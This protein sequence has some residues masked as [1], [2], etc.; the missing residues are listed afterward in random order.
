MSL[1]RPA[2]SLWHTGARLLGGA[3]P[4]P[5]LS[6]GGKPSGTRVHGVEWIRAA[7]PM[8]GLRIEHVEA[9]PGGSGPNR[10]FGAG[11]LTATGAN[12]L[13]WQAPYESVAGPETTVLPEQTVWVPGV[14]PTGAVL[15]TRVLDDALSGAET[16]VLRP[17]YHNVIGGDD[18][19][20]AGPIKPGDDVIRYAGL[21]VRNEHTSETVTVK[22]YRIHY[23][24]LSYVM[25]GFEALDAAGAMQTI[26]DGATAPVGVT[27]VDIAEYANLPPGA[28]VGLWIKRTVIGLV[29]PVV[30]I[31]LQL[32]SSA[33]PYG[34]HIYGG[35]TRRGALSSTGYL[36]QD[37]GVTVATSATLPI[38]HALTQGTHR[39]EVLRRN[40]YDLVS[41]PRGA[42][43]IVVGAGGEHEQTPPDP[44]H[45]AQVYARTQGRA[46][47]EAHCVPALMA[48]R[49]THWRVYV[50]LDGTDP[51]PATDTP[52]T[53]AITPGRW[54][55][56]QHEIAST[57]D[58][59]PIRVLVRTAIQTDP[60][61]ETYVESAN[62]DVL[63]T[64]SRW[65][66]PQVRRPRARIEDRHGQA[67][68]YAPPASPVWIDP[69]RNVRWAVTD[70]GVELWA[71]TSLVWVV[72]PHELR[73]SY[74][75]QFADLSG[76]A[77]DTVEIGQW[78]AAAR[79]IWISVAG[80][81]RMRVDAV[82]RT[83]TVAALDT[84]GEV[85]A[86]DA[87][88]PCWPRYDNTVLQ[89]WDGVSGLWETALQ[90]QEDGVLRAAVAVAALGT[91]AACL[92]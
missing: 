92:A 84:A 42:H 19:V 76:A 77:A 61:L 11:T 70:S 90:L 28:S 63:S 69:A 36:L 65:Y 64:T 2:L 14:A 51:D 68:H 10:A 54:N 59:T 12:T 86:S 32:E 26:P 6:L 17:P 73:T 41:S 23:P 75:I 45:E 55:R 38:T 66:G 74:G 91:E 21:V 78:D 27:F 60:E 22:A 35:M 87:P 85:T 34:Y 37:N 82:A 81:R 9:T 80:Q 72:T 15:V 58:G 31:I 44:P 7:A 3:Q 52:V 67:L 25:A 50:R 29:S 24:W 8:R 33:V 71:D 56:L 57:L 43:T 4:D 83:I 49:P 88:V 46:L 40:R 79:E 1:D 39:V 47:V 89:V 5:R 30:E 18:A 13:T 20:T 16:V 48:S 53:V 62:T